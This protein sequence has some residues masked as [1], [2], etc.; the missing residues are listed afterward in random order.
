MAACNFATSVELSQQGHL[1]KASVL[2][3]DMRLRA[4]ALEALRQWSFKPYLLN[5]VPTEV[6]SELTI[7]VR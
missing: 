6:K 1:A 7:Y 4:A 2:E 3:G 5:R